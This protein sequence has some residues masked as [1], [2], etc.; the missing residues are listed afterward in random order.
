MCF[1]FH[2]GK[3]MWYER[4]FPRAKC[5]RADGRLI[6]LD[7]NGWLTLATASP[8]RLTI[9]SRCNVTERWSL[10]PPT[11]VGTILYIRDERHIIA[12]DVRKSATNGVG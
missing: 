11:L 10:T 4:D 1:D 6:I 8:E 12:L 5:V 3:R 9:H 2:A 7:E